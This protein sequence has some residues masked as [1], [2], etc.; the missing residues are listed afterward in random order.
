M[1]IT[2]SH[3]FRITHY[4][5]GQHRFLTGVG[6]EVAYHQGPYK[7]KPRDWHMSLISTIPNDRKSV[8]SMGHS[9]K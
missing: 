4:F 8:L 5:D 2:V 7:A 6:K 1:I 3:S 9:I